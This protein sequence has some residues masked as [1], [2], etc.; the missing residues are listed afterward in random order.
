MPAHLNTDFGAAQWVLLVDDDTFVFY[1]NLA[2]HL[3][4]LDWSQRVYTGL[5]SPSSWIPTNLS[6][7][8]HTD[9][10]Q[11]DGFVNSYDLFVNGGSGSVFSRA[12]LLDLDTPDCI[13]EMK[14]TGR[15]WQYQSDWALG[16]CVRRRGVFP[17][18]APRGLFNQFVCVDREHHPFYCEH[19]SD[20]LARGPGVTGGMG[21]ARD[22]LDGDLS[23]PCTIHPLKSAG[24][25][26]YL[27]R[28]Y[29]SSRWQET[30]NVTRAR[31]DLGLRPLTT[32]VAA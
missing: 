8:G 10:L 15:W 16:A 30:R 4:T 28:R 19:A 12:A 23:M 6:Y 22:D 5:V 29:A 31:E 25:F 21:D 9:G 27:W 3:R 20:R 2:M 17:K 14:P 18:Q 26:E 7:V 13:Q 11:P 1:Q 24:A 32:R